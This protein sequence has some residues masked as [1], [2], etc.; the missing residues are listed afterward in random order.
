M[1]LGEVL[2]HGKK[3]GDCK[4]GRGGERMARNERIGPHVVRD[5]I[6]I[7]MDKLRKRAVVG[8]CRSLAARLA[9]K[10]VENFK[11]SSIEIF[12]ALVRDRAAERGSMFRLPCCGWRLS[13]TNIR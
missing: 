11:V 2:S 8:V 13:N 5:G 6:I 4:V 10:L 3:E 9:S 7:I 1:K 12:L